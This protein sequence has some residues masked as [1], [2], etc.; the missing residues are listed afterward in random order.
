MSGLKVI[1]TALSLNSALY[2]FFLSVFFRGMVVTSKR[3]S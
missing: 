1:F 2:R 3:W